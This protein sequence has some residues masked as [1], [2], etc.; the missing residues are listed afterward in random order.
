MRRYIVILLLIAVG[1]SLVVG[2]GG[3]MGE[4]AAEEPMEAATEE[5]MEEAAAEEPM[6]EAAEEPME[7]VAAET[8]Q[9]EPL[10]TDLDSVLQIQT[11]EPKPVIEY[12]MLPQLVSGEYATLE[13]AENQVISSAT[14]DGDLGI[15]VAPVATLEDYYFDDDTYLGLALGQVWTL[16]T[17][18]EE[19]EGYVVALDPGGEI[20][21]LVNETMSEPYQLTFQSEV[22]QPQTA[23]AFDQARAVDV[24]VR[25]DGV[26]F[27]VKETEQVSR[28]CTDDT[29]LSTRDRL[30]PAYVS[31]IDDAVAYAEMQLAEAA[32]LLPD[33]H[34]VLRDK[35][36]SEME[37]PDQIAGC[38]L[39][40]QGSCQAD[41]IVAPI[42]AGFE[43]PPSSLPDDSRL[44]AVGL[45]VLTKGI[46]L[47][48]LVGNDEG[49]E[50]LAEIDYW[51]PSGSYM[52][53]DEYSPDGQPRGLWLRG[54]TDD[55]QRLDYLPM[56]SRL[57]PF[58]DENNDLGIVEIMGFK[59]SRWCIMWECS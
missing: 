9:L 34:T 8:L 46:D 45:L 11:I 21:Y 5:P 58:V 10:V 15:T 42:D 29:L 38:D 18:T 39:N 13:L 51:L 56:P 35:A 44:R 7:E 12:Q 20:G 28:H 22:L 33:V 4:P 27:L 23:T 53:S 36:V 59:I 37:G 1:Y 30:G 47:S 24:T 2:C 43:P 52:L 50:Q 54:Q 14:L 55:G 32:F 26:C 16:P 57:A 41:V 48:P 17:E 31:T 40:V 19:A 3:E 6:E 49:Y 25:A